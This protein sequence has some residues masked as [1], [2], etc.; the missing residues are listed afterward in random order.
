[1]VSR[2]R[3]TLPLAAPF[4]RKFDSLIESGLDLRVLAC[5]RAN[6]PAADELV[7][8]APTRS[9]K[10]FDGLLFYAS[11]PTLIAREIRGFHPEV[12]VVQGVHE[13]VAALIARTLTRSP[14]KVI[15]DLQGNWRAATRLYGSPA[16]RLLNPLSDGLGRIAVRHADAVRTIGPYTTTLVRELGVEPRASFPTYVDRTSFVAHAPLSLPPRPQALFVGVLERY[17]GIDT[18]L[19]AWP[20]VAREIPEARLRIVGTGS[21]A[22]SVAAAIRDPSLHVRWT[23]E[24]SG[25]EIA[26]ALDES[27]LLVLPSRMEGMG[28]V[29]IEAFARARPV[30]GTRS[31]GIVDLVDDGRT[32][33]LVEP[34]DRVELADALIRLL[35]DRDLAERLGAAALRSTEGWLLEPEQWAERFLELVKAV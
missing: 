7:R 31:G 19:D 26:E 25:A 12:I 18:L 35:D 22:R 16:R 33:L 28:R 24:L 2:A 17:K 11:L 20:I 32:G 15:L 21:R 3:Y 13:A 1:M 4:Q 30:V 23:P 29:V 27:T 34:G 9:P 8:L 14:A 10:L 5:T 6:T